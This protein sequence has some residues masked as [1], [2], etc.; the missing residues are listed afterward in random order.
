M[1]M[2]LMQRFK[3]SPLFRMGSGRMMRRLLVSPEGTNLIEFAF[4]VPLLV[5]MLLGTIDI[6]QLAYVYIE[7]SNAARAGVAYGAQTH[8]TASDDPGMTQ[9]A[10][11]DAPNMGLTATPAHF[12]E[13]SDGS[14]STC[15][16]GACS[17]DHLVE[18]VQVDTSATYQPWF[19]CPGI[20]SSVTVTGTA[21]MRAGE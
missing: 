4:V 6:G 1:N 21:K 8:V 2:K 16:V 18:Y 10:Q 20:P 3:A 17:G 5:V 13:C 11:N 9:A 14:P 12:C 19:P 15:S 7:V